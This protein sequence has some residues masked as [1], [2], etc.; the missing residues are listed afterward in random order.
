MRPVRNPHAGRP[1][2]PEVTDQEI[3]A[4][5]EDLSV[6]ALLMA[7]VHL[8]EDD[9]QRRAILDGSLRPQGLFLNEYQG[10]MSPEDL[11]AVRELSLIH[12]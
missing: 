9:A 5:L 12:I 1:I 3:A 6:P 4:A 2:P 8:V 11:A 7:C 10:Y